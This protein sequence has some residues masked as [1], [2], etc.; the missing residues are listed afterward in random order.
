MI[1]PFAPSWT[2]LR[3]ASLGSPAKE[4]RAHIQI[5]QLDQNPLGSPPEKALAGCR[6]RY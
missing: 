2:I 1:E 3:K 5:N 6:L 4:N